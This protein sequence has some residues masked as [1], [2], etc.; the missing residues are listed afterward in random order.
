MC[1]VVYGY[2][3][4]TYMMYYSNKPNCGEDINMYFGNGMSRTNWRLQHI[5]HGLNAQFLIG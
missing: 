3:L 2:S 5:Y 1:D 4:I